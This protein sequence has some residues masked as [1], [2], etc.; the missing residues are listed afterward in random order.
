M[1]AALRRIYTIDGDD[2]TNYTPDE[3]DRFAVVLRMFVGSSPGE[4]EESFDVTVCTP[5]WLQEAC[6]RDGF[7]L[8]RHLFVVQAYN[9]EFI[10]AKLSR[11]IER[12]SGATW[13]EVAA[14]VGRIGY[15]EFED[16][17]DRT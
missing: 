1:R 8:G 17:D 3:P 2:P 11:L 9:F 12:Y 14:R 7:V 13:R 6:D 10:R 15:W 16:Y 5:L 4:G